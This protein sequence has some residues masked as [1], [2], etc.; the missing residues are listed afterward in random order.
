[1]RGSGVAVRQGKPPPPVARR[2]R[3]GTA[4]VGASRD[5]PAATATAAPAPCT[6]LRAPAARYSSAPASSR[7]CVPPGGG[8][9]EASPWGMGGRSGRVGGGGWGKERV[10]RG[11]VRIRSWVGPATRFFIPP[12][13][14][15]TR[16]T[17]DARPDVRL[18][19]TVYSS[20]PCPP[21][22]LV[23]CGQG[24]KA[25]LIPFVVR[26]GMASASSCRRRLP[27]RGLSRSRRSRVLYPS[28]A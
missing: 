7:R 28:A 15:F 26:G 20:V 1:M 22:F 23:V 11:A 3:A 17:P 2:P 16:P 24:R 10:G 12:R 13:R 25:F 9:R 21:S 4:L 27:Q 5:A 18:S 19:I 6:A 8:G 14:Q